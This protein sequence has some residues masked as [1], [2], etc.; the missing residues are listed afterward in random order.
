MKKQKL[1]KHHPSGRNSKRGSHLKEKNNPP[2][3]VDILG[4]IIYKIEKE[5][6]KIS[7]RFPATRDFVK[8]NE[9]FFQASG[10]LI[11]AILFID[12]L[13]LVVK[14]NNLSALAANLPEK[15]GSAS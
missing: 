7:A 13:L 4:E 10:I 15:A 5:N 11:L 3:K 6:A 1:K 14:L 9:F 2:T 8:K 12:C